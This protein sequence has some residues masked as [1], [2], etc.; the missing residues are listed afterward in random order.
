MLTTKPGSFTHLCSVLLATASWWAPLTLTAVQRQE[1]T[2]TSIPQA[3]AHLTAL[4]P[5]N[6]TDRLT[7]AIN[8][9]LRN[10]AELNQLLHDLY[11]PA[12][13]MYRQWRTPAQLADQFG[14]TEADYAAVIAWAQ[15]HG[16][17]VTGKLPNRLVLNVEGSVAAIQK[18]FNV[19]LHVYDHPTEHRTFYAPD[20]KPSMD[21]D[22]AVLS[23][24]GLDNFSLPHPMNHVQPLDYVS[25]K[26]GSA[27]GG[28]YAACDFRNAYVPGTTLTGTGQ[29]VAL[30]Q[31]DGYYTLDINNYET[32]FGLPA[33]PLVNVAINGGVPTPGSGQ[34]EVCLDI[35]MSMSMAPGLS[36]IYVY[37]GPNGGTA[38]STILGR[39]QT[40]NLAKQVSC[41]WGNTGAGTDPASENIFML[42]KGQGQSFFNATGD[43]DAF[44][45]AIPF[46]SESTNITQVGG[47]TLNTSGGA[48]GG[49]YVSEHVWNWNNGTGSSGGISTDYGIPSYQAGVSMTSNQG[50]TTMR[51]VPDVALTADNIY[52]RYNNGG[53]G[54]F[55]GTSCAA[56]LWA[57]FTALVNQQ[58]VAAGHGTVGFLN[59][60]LYAIGSSPSYT[61]NFHDI[62][63]GNNFSSSSPS[64]YSAAAGYDLCTG[65]GTPNGTNLINSL[66]GPA[67]SIPILVAN[68]S[69]LVQ[70]TCTN[71]AVDPG[72]TVSMSFGL[73]NLGS[74]NTTNLVA[75]LLASGGVTAPSGPQ[76]FGA[77]VAGGPAVSRT[78]SFTATG[79]C[80]GTNVATLQLSDGGTS[81][82]TVTFSFRLGQLVTSFSE[83]FDEVTAPALPTGWASSATGVE[84]P[85]VTVTSSYDTAPNSVFAPDPGNI[86]ES[87][88]D[89]PPIT[90]PAVPMQLSFRHSYDTECT[91]DGG[92]LEI[93]IGGGAWT[94]ILAAGGAFVTGGYDGPISTQ[95][96]NPLAGRNSWNCSSGG[97]MTTVVNLPFAA[98][99]QTI[100][101]RWLM[102]SDNSNSGTGWYIDTISISAT[103]PVC[104][105]PAP[106]ITS[107][108]QN[109]GV[110]TL[111]WTAVSGRAYQVLYKT[112]LSQAT[113][114]VLT[115]VGATGSTASATDT[116]APG[117]R[118]YR[119]ALLP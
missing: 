87:E 111:D 5:K 58:S 88:L 60:A 118:F 2:Q 104:C 75:T 57:G 102:G 105:A 38:W 49:T 24:N 81:L 86:G 11:D 109:A 10:V 17:T 89:S 18:A 36:T 76:T 108:N 59:P 19:T 20:T 95:Y 74:A 9:P 33:V 72:E 47:T 119:I 39:I 96:G 21:L 67:I 8:L 106:V 51:N 53:S 112:D 77:V 64:H 46:P 110:V 100:Q 73:K 31:F 69:T 114:S 103:A 22:T 29:S 71:N 80:G 42:M 16:L 115:T 37:E 40:D 12:S 6:P 94:D 44:V 70:E 55:G 101:L 99:G 92:V 84:S 34:G 4:G 56:P 63:V 83:N 28:A 15:S 23:I 7:L 25:P 78:F 13:P 26:G 30:L 48:C 1:I 107:V 62:T 85:W 116:L 82:G 93:K 90:L 43:G 27:P 45:G 79:T 35:E 117:Q 50:S 41:S 113:W 98:E 32:E 66:A 54:N 97:F 61:L 14:G 65:W 91:F 3:V 68:S 52:V